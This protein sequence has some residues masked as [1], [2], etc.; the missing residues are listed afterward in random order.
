MECETCSKG[1]IW[2]HMASSAPGYGTQPLHWHKMHK[3]LWRW[4]KGQ[5]GQKKLS[6]NA[7]KVLQSAHIQRVSV[8]C[9]SVRILPSSRLMSA[10]KAAKFLRTFVMSTTSNQFKSHIFLLNFLKL[11]VAAQDYGKLHWATFQKF[12]KG[13]TGLSPHHKI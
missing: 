5:K 1:D 13:Q 4:K 6:K 8:S 2:K 12:L 7:Q 11:V 9:M 3:R 10:R